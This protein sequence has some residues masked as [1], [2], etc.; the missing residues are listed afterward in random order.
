MR[1]NKKGHHN[2]L[3]LLNGI[4]IDYTLQYKQQLADFEIFY[5]FN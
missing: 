5:I 2:Q 1:N 4:C 3:D